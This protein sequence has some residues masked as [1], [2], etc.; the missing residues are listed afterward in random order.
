MF[1]VDHS[2]VTQGDMLPASMDNLLAKL[3]EQQAVLEKQ[4]SSLSPVNK[5]GKHHQKGESSSSSILLTP[6]SDKS[7]DHL[8]KGNT[9]GDH[10]KGQLDAKE[11]SRLQKELDAAKNQIA[12][13]K[14][15]LDET[16]VIKH[17][18]SQ[19]MTSSPSP[20]HDEIQETSGSH[21]GNFNAVHRPIGARQDTWSHNEDAR[22]EFSDS[23]SGGVLN[24]GQSIW[25]APT[26]PA[27]NAGILPAANQQF[28]PQAPTWGQPGARPWNNT[29]VT[30]LPQLVVPQQQMQ[31]RTFSGP[32]SPASSNDSG[33]MNDYNQ[34]SSGVGNRRSVTQNASNAPVYSQRSNGW[35]TY[36]GGIQPVNGSN[37]SLDPNAAFQ[38][39]GLYP[40]TIQYQPRP[41]GTPLSP[42][43]EEFRATQPSAT[44]WNAAASI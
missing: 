20:G 35:D 34:F 37:L 2:S 39:V 25:N 11:M 40:S 12:R 32:A 16:R 1:K 3:S 33:L 8:Q 24:A 31:Q 18:L 15:E 38:S 23:T 21:Q 26:R 36:T 7:S 22:S 29:A 42:T 17:T 14:Q 5:D 44:P 10:D 30:T 19:A 13:Q 27:F 6:R 41:I 28:Q 4:K 9:K 43:A